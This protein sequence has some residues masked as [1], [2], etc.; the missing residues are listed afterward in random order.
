MSWG[1]SKYTV[2]LH[3]WHKPRAQACVTMYSNEIQEGR[4]PPTIQKLIIPM[5]LVEIDRIKLLRLMKIEGKF[6]NYT[7]VF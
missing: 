3:Q 4:R 2:F 1:A 5:V 7:G 6:S